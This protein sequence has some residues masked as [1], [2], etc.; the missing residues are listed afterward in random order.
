M[1]DE[2]REFRVFIHV[3]QPIMNYETIA[4]L[5]KDKQ[6]VEKLFQDLQVGDCFQVRQSDSFYV[7]ESAS[8]ATRYYPTGERVYKNYTP[9][10]LVVKCPIGFIS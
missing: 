3:C 6:T 10:E 2:E 4:L 7:K 5:F 8:H 9:A 1:T